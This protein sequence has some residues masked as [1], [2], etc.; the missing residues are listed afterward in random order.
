MRVVVDAMRTE[1]APAL[2]FLSIDFH[3]EGPGACTAGFT[4]TFFSGRT[5]EE[6]LTDLADFVRQQNSIAGMPPGAAAAAQGAD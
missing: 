2:V 4:Y 5:I 1:A 6:N 3:L